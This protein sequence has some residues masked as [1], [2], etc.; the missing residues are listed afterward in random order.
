MQSVEQSARAKWPAGTA[1]IDGEVAVAIFHFYTGV[2]LDVDNIAKPILDAIK[3]IIL[4]DDR[5][6]SQLFVR[7][8]NLGILSSIQA[9]PPEIAAAIGQGGDFIWLKV[10][11]PPMHNVLP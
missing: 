7:R 9:P 5:I 10:D 2:E 4:A 6:I 8:T 3:G 1:P 11:G